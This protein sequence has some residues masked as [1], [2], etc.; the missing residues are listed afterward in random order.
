MDSVPSVCPSGHGLQ[1]P[2]PTL[3]GASKPFALHPKHSVPFTL[4]PRNRGSLQN[5]RSI[6]S[7]GPEE[8]VASHVLRAYPSKDPPDNL[9]RSTNCAVRWCSGAIAIGRIPALE[10]TCGVFRRARLPVLRR[11]MGQVSVKI[12][13]LFG[14]RA[15]TTKAVRLGH[16]G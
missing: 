1:W 5:S 8:A 4:N 10:R 9:G 11:Y 2:T 15:F 16:A 7:S 13:R 3:C 12:S 14:G 6:Q